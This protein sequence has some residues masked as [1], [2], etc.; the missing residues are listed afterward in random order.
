MVVSRFTISFALS[1]L[2]VS[3]F[4]FADSGAGSV[5]GEALSPESALLKIRNRLLGDWPTKQEW[6]ELAQEKAAR[7]CNATECMKDFYQKKISEYMKS[8]RYVGQM[9]VK[10]EELFSLRSGPISWDRVVNPPVDP[11]RTGYDSRSNERRSGEVLNAFSDLSRRMFS[12][13][14]SWDELYTSQKYQIYPG[15]NTR[16]GSPESVFYGVEI[17]PTTSSDPTKIN[18]F[19]VNLVDQPNASGAFTTP[20]FLSR[21]WNSSINQGRK[22]SAAVFKIMICDPLFPALERKSVAQEESRKALGV[23]EKELAEIHSTNVV[24]KHATDPACIRC[25]QRLDPLAWTMRGLEVGISE[26]AFPGRVR[27]YDEQ[28]KLT[29]FQVDNFH[30]AI[31]T[32][33]QQAKYRSCQTNHMLRWIVGHDVR[34]TD[35][36]RSEIEQNF[37][38]VGRRTNDFISYLLLSPEFLSKPKKQESRVTDPNTPA[39]LGQAAFEKVVPILNQCLKCH[40]NSYPFIGER[41]VVWDKSR[42]ADVA[43]VLDLANDGKSRTMPPRRNQWQT[44]PEDL[45]AIKSWIQQGAPNSQGQPVLQPN[46][47]T[48]VLEGK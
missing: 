7:N 24:N 42:L 15:A 47:I 33:T 19:A 22:R 38:R 30:Q 46:E 41:E 35:Q 10:V 27:F 14:L 2:L 44:T 9:A 48:P 16:S 4:A 40:G 28:G 1:L 39:A 32:I 25:H 6:T 31:R 34:M 13:N 20:R 26:N 11:T 17:Q 29:N 45:A 18:P 21:Y 3:A 36:R 8:P 37:D 5:T 12:E 23:T 43:Y